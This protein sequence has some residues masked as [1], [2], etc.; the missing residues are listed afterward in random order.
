MHATRY[1][2]SQF[3]AG[4]ANLA[5][6]QPTPPADDQDLAHWL[7]EA[8]RRRPPAKVEV[9]AA[10]LP[11]QPSRRARRRTRVLVPI[12]AGVT[13][14]AYL[15]YFY[16]DVMLQIYSLQHLIVFILVDGLPP[17]V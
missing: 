10:T 7:R 6:V 15:Q 2:S 11:G 4:A 12:L 14:L 16:V 3:S 5:A 17:P 1:F 13:A 9:G 8:G